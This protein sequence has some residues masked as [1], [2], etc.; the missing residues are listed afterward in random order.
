M[1]D[2][3]ERID[4]VE[5]RFFKFTPSQGL[6]ILANLQKMIGGSIFDLI[7]A[8]EDAENMYSIVGKALDKLS[9]RNSAE[10]VQA[11]ITSVVTSGSIVVNKQKIQH[12]DEL[13]EFQTQTDPIY[14]MMT[15]FKEQV[16]YS[17]SGFLGKMV[18]SLPSLPKEAAPAES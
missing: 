14:L 4:G 10:D 7:E 13:G 18:G 16:V 5:C 3:T 9:D 8:S 2:K 15:L 11:L 12:L 17:F 1:Q 6:P